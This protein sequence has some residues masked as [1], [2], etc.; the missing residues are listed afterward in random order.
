MPLTLFGDCASE[1]IQAAK[2]SPPVARHLSNK[3][4]K[5]HY[6]FL[7]KGVLQRQKLDVS[8]S[9]NL[10]RGGYYPQGTIINDAFKVTH[11]PTN[12]H[13]R[14]LSV[15][16]VFDVEKEAN[17]F[18]ADVHSYVNKTPGVSLIEDFQCTTIQKSHPCP[19][20]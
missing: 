9:L 17:L 18:I 5:N 4:E 1:L 10:A 6:W 16:V 8:N 11:H 20:E 7:C 12:P 13:S 14:L 3:L 2:V 19:R 15:S